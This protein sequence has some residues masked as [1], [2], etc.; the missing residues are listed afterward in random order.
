MPVHT[1]SPL[2]THGVIA[3][4]EGDQLTIWAST[5]GIATVRDGI[6]E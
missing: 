3:Q 2:E 1:H 4:W 6:A 5:Q